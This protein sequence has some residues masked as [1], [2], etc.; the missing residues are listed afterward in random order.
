MH[1]LRVRVYVSFGSIDPRG[2][3]TE[4]P[5]KRDIATSFFSL[6]PFSPKED[7][8]D[9]YLVWNLDFN[10]RVTGSGFSQSR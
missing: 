9:S 2:K 8:K 5:V 10:R 1:K 3:N 4:L 6:S 7:P